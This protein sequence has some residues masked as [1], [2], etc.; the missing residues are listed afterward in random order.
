MSSLALLHYL[1]IHVLLMKYIYRLMPSVFT[2]ISSPAIHLSINPIQFTHQY[3]S[4]VYKY[5][6]SGKCTQKLTTKL[7]EARNVYEDIVQYPYIQQ[8]QKAAIKV[9]VSS[10]FRTWNFLVRKCRTSGERMS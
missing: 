2:I 9:T 5:L 4:S 10:I 7:N 8:E 3:P 1:T 6:E